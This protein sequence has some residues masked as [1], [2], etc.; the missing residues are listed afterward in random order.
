MRI[1]KT[2]AFT[3]WASKAGLP[4]DSLRAAVK[5][6]EEGLVDAHLGGYLYKK[7]VA[8]QGSGK[9][10]GTRTLL[11]YR[12]NDK[13]FF[14]Y[15]FAKNVRASIKKDEEKA[16]KLYAKELMS[17]NDTALAD[18]VKSGVLVEVDKSG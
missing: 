12:S 2:R 8:V 11:A 4:D 1:F 7:R 10:G 5:E 3:K 14:I 15:G 17:H 9:R 16:L 18:A 13:T 6:I